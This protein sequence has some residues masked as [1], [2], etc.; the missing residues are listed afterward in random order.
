MTPLARRGGVEYGFTGVVSKT[1]QRIDAA[2]GAPIEDNPDTFQDEAFELSVETERSGLREVIVPDSDGRFTVSVTNP[3]PRLGIDD[4]DVRV[5][6]TLEK[7][8]GNDMTII[9]MTMPTGTVSAPTGRVVGGHELGL[10]LRAILR[11]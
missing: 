10:C 5:K 6:V 7:V 3:D 11:R 4:P 2:T 1:T 9:D 8:R